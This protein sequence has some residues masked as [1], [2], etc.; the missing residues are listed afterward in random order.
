VKEKSE[1]EKEK[2]KRFWLREDK[3]VFL[4]E[5]RFLSYPSTPDRKNNVSD[6]QILS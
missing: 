6:Q 2:E 1:R 4:V 3:F 5:N